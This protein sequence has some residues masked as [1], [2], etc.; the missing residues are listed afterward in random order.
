MIHYTPLPP[1]LIFY[2]PEESASSSLREVMIDGVQ[3]LVEINPT[4]ELKIVRLLSGNPMHYLD[5]RLQ[6][7][8]ILQLIPKI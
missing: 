6:P 1:E 4:M 8:N 5:P 7:G 2:N 3:M